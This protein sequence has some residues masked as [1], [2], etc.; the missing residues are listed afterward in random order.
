[1]PAARSIARACANSPLPIRRRAQRLEAILHPL[2]RAETARP[3]QRH[4]GG[5]IVFDVPLLIESGRW[6][7]RS[8]ACW[9]STAARPRRSNA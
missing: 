2:I 6:R 5:T 1:M 4:E 3:G 9:W 8:N 7:A